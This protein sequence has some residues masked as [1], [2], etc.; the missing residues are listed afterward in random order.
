M[1]QRAKA[2]GEQFNLSLIN[3]SE[4]AIPQNK[5]NELK[6]ALVE[7]LTSAVLPE[8]EV[9]DGRRGDEDESQTNG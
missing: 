9:L 2:I 1:K 3:R 4:T 6:R 5:Q 7:L 8:E